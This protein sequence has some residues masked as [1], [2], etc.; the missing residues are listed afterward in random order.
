MRRSLLLLAVMVLAVEAIAG[1]RVLP[2]A[3]LESSVTLT[4]TEQWRVGSEGAVFDED[5][6]PEAQ[7]VVCYT[8]D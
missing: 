3:P 2:T 5:D 8:V 6:V 1:D 4:L 7:E